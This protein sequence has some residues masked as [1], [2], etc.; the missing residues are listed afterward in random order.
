M[1]D[2]QRNGN[3]GRTTTIARAHAKRRYSI[4]ELVTAAY[5]NAALLTDDA[6]A[7]AI[8]ASRT[9]AAWLAKSDHPE[10]ID[11]LRAFPA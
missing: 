9:L 10:I 2:K 3:K 7:A 4:G 11:R 6:E 8:I 1:S 5:R